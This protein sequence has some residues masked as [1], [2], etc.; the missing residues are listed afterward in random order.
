MASEVHA[1]GD[2]LPGDGHVTAMGPIKGEFGLKASATTAPGLP[3]VMLLAMASRNVRV[4]RRLLGLGTA[5]AQLAEAE[6]GMMSRVRRR[7]KAVRMKMLQHELM[8]K[9]Q[10]PLETIFWVGIFLLPYR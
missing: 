8:Y 5:P 9:S 6:E 2:V 7:P 1:Y 3:K 10:C 4:Q